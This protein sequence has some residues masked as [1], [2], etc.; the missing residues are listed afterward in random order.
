MR[1]CVCLCVCDIPP[2]PPSSPP[3]YTPDPSPT[4]FSSFSPLQGDSG[5]PLMC[6]PP[7]H[8]GHGTPRRWYQVGIVSWG[9][10]CAAPRSPGV[11]TQ[12]A[13][14][15]SWLEQTSAH[16]GRPFRVPQIP[17]SL[18][19]QPPKTDDLWAD[20]ESGAGPGAPLAAG[21]GSAT[22]AVALSALG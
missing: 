3:R 20:V 1:V 15:H 22:L 16:D 10:S 9:R 8:S 12:V 14:F 18:P 21:L 11:Y 6:L 4:P 17:A 7:S 13:N 19:L 2:P 5:G